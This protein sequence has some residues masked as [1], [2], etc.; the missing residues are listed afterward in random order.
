MEFPGIVSGGK[1]LRLWEEK[2]PPQNGYVAVFNFPTR[3]EGW[4]HIWVSVSIPPSTSSFWWN[5]DGN[6][7]H[8]V[9]GGNLKLFMPKFYGVSDVMAWLELTKVFLKPGQHELRIMV[10]ERRVSHEKAYLLYL[11]ALFITAEDVVPQGLVEEKDIPNLPKRKDLEVKPVKRAVVPGEPLVLGTSVQNVGMLK[12]LGF[13]LFQTDSDHLTVNET[14]PG[15][16]DWSQADEALEICRRCEVDWQYFPHFHWA[17]EWYRKTDKFVPLRSVADGRELNIISLWSPHMPEWLDHCYKALAEHYGSDNS[18]IK[19]IYVGLYGD[20]GEAHFPAG[21]HPDEVKRF[22]KDRAAIPDWWCGDPYAQADFRGKMKQ[23][24]RT[25]ESLNSAWATNFH[26]FEDLKC[27]PDKLQLDSAGSRRQWLD[28]INWRYDCMTNYCEMVCRIARKYFPNTLLVIPLGCG[29][30]DLRHAQ[31][32][33][34]LPKMAKKYGVHVRSTHGGY[35]PFPQNYAM[36]LKRIATACKFYDVPFWTEP[37]GRITEDGEVSR[38]FEAI[39]CRSYGYWDWAFNPTS[40]PHVFQKYKA[41]LTREE[42]LVDVALFYPSTDACL[43]PERGYSPRFQE[44]AAAIRDVMD[45]DIVD[46]QLILDGVLKNYRV[47]IFF[48]GQFVE[49]EVLK[50]IDSWVRNSGGVVVAYN[51]GA[52]STVEGDTSIWTKLFGRN[53]KY[54]GN[55]EIGRIENFLQHVKDLDPSVSKESLPIYVNRVGKGYVIFLDRSWDS[56]RLYYALLQDVVYN[57]SALDPSKTDAIEVDS[58]FDGVY[59]TLLPSGEV[60]VHNF[61]N[62]P[63]TAKVAGQEVYLERK[64]LAS[65][66]VELSKF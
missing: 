12:S 25:I 20:F 53:G 28:F 38:F 26:S 52:V 66:K 36:M 43:H 63:V 29:D 57:L 65:F 27:P 34:A 51:F 48:E 64:S 59:C 8:H 3:T 49:K 39:S 46:E 24:Y 18:K 54:Q 31:D 7:F 40:S 17:P 1:I 13:T 56:K 16:W 9:T 30:E 21:Y 42:P 19:A 41:F 15:V 35:L 45:Y 6:G 14:S 5:I 47:L 55:F 10:N 60:I 11:D 50:K 33:T 22:G 44:G 2:D 62:E 32:N 58:S 23:K 61:N 37:P 4:Y